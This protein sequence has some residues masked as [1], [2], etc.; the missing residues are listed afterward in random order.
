[1]EGLGTAR[2]RPTVRFILL[3]KIVLLEPGNRA[4]GFKLIRA[5]EEYFRDHFPGYAV[6]PGVL[7]LESMAQLGGRL[8]TASVKAASGREVLPMLAMANR[9]KF[10]QSVRP[11]DQLDVTAE[12]MTMSGD[13]ARVEASAEVGGVGVASA[14]ISYVL[15]G[16]DQNAA[17]MS[18]DELA[19]VREWDARTWRDLTG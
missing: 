8:I 10:R 18:P 2:R 4:R 7:V 13:R 12:I 1:M 6:V 5:D 17:G 11:G 14:E 9:V 16:Y 19:A 3:D 15:L